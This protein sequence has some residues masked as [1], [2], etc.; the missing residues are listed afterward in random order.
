M[1]CATRTPFDF[2]GHL[3]L[4]FCLW[5]VDVTRTP[6][7]PGIP[8]SGTNVRTDEIERRSRV[9]VSRLRSLPLGHMPSWPLRLQSLR[10]M[11]F[12]HLECA[13]F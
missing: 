8:G 6:S 7:I 11:S 10:L 3:I 13:T 2:V 1:R 5:V 9:L 12:E 4:L